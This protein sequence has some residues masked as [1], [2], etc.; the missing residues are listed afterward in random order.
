MMNTTLGSD[1]ALQGGGMIK[2]RALSSFHNQTDSAYI[3]PDRFIHLRGKSK[4]GSIGNK[5]KN[6]QD[7]GN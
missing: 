4:N 1:V 6:T 7:K 2:Y 3:S 5:V